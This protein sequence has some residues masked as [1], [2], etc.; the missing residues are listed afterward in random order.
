M[1]IE[2]RTSLGSSTRKITMTNTI[3]QTKFNIPSN[4]KLIKISGVMETAH[5]ENG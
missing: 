5:W 3:I 1:L 2:A 4:R